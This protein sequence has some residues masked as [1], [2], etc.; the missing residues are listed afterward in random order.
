VPVPATAVCARMGVGLACSTLHRK[1]IELKRVWWSGEHGRW[2]WRG[3]S[4]NGND[5]SVNTYESEDNETL[6]DGNGATGL[7]PSAR[8]PACFE[9]RW[10]AVL[11]S[12]SG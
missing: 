1:S 7:R 5:S 9:L 6:W 3:R 2:P 4:K 8:L 11:A 12:S 10:M